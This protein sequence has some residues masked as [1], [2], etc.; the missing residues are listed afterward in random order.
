M[1][2]VSPDLEGINILL[3]LPS[4]PLPTQILASLGAINSMCVSVRHQIWTYSVTSEL[5]AHK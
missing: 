3:M 5:T 2:L 1:V 4:Q